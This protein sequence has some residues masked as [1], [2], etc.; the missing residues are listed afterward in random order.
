M[1]QRQLSNLCIGWIVVSVPWQYHA[2]FVLGKSI[3]RVFQIKKVQHIFE[4]VINILRNEN[5]FTGFFELWNVTAYPV[6]ID[7]V[8]LF[9]CGKTFVAIR[10]TI[11]W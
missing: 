3:D 10:I 7:V 4:I 8:V 1:A 6:T 11:P 2:W 5:A 9:R